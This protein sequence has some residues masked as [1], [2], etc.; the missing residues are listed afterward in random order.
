M[1][2]CLIQEREKANEEK[3]GRQKDDVEKKKHQKNRSLN[4]MRDSRLASVFHTCGVCD[5]VRGTEWVGVLKR[6]A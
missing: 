1:H 6:D 4:K 3:L 5:E 2:F